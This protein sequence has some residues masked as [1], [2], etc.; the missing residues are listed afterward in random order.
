MGTLEGLDGE[1]VKQKIKDN[2]W[3]ILLV[4]WQV[5]CRLAPTIA[6]LR[7]ADLRAIATGV[8]HPAADQLPLRS[9]EVSSACC[10]TRYRAI[11]DPSPV[12]V[13]SSLRLSFVLSGLTF[14]MLSADPCAAARS[15]RNLVDLLPQ[16]PDSGQV[17]HSR[18]V[19]RS[20]F[21]NRPKSATGSSVSS[22]TISPSLIAREGMRVP[23]NERLCQP[24]LSLSAICLLG[25]LGITYHEK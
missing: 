4:N 10:A 7:E 15:A 24:D 2:Y 14:S 11:A 3:A 17:A 23:D 9:F 21:L 8:A 12:Q 16:L 20:L 1:G 5:R 13:P 25:N 18:G 6:E 22:V 19:K